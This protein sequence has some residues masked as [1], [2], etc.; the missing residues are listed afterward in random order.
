MNQASAEASLHPVT[1]LREYNHTTPR[2]PYSLP[3][4][5]ASP[6]DAYMSVEPVTFEGYTDYQYKKL[7]RE[8]GEG[9]VPLSVSSFAVQDVVGIMRSSKGVL[10]AAVVWTEDDRTTGGDWIPFEDLNVLP[11]DGQDEEEDDL[12]DEDNENAPVLTPAEVEEALEREVRRHNWDL[13]FGQAVDED[14]EVICGFTQ[15]RD[16]TTYQAIVKDYDENTGAHQIHFP[17]MAADKIFRTAAQSTKNDFANLR[18]DTVHIVSDTGDHDDGISFWVKKTF[19]Q[20][21]FIY[22]KLPALKVNDE[23]PPARQK[24]PRPRCLDPADAPSKKKPSQSKKHVEELMQQMRE[25]PL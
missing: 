19:V 15:G 2:V 18:L 21:P 7:L 4:C 14:L 24:R 17:V 8:A 22:E 9:Q 23:D 12:S 5:I 10:K 20:L 13:Y 3:D 1:E 6:S 11:P 16:T 25:T